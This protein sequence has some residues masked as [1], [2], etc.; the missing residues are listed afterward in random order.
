ML[1][2]ITTDITR[3]GGGFTT[4][5]VEVACGCGEE[6]LQSNFVPCFSLVHEHGYGLKQN[7]VLLLRPVRDSEFF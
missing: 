4:G 3:G 5:G 1:A 7:F 6:S 2:E